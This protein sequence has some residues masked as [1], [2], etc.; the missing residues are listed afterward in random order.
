MYKLSLF[1]SWRWLSLCLALVSGTGA[2]GAPRISE[3][4]AANGSFLADEDGVFSDWIEIHNPDVSP[5]SLAGY[6]LTDNPGNLNK[7]TFPAVTLNPGAYLVVFASG[8]NRIDPAGRLHTDFQLSADGGYLAL[9]APDGVTVVSGF[10]PAYP[11]Q[12]ENESFGLGQPRRRQYQPHP[13]VES[14]GQLRERLHHG[15]AGL[16]RERQFG[17]PRSRHRRRQQP[18]LFVVRFFEPAGAAPV[19][20]VVTS[21]TLAWRGTV[22][23]TLIGAPTVNSLLGVFRCRMPG[24]ELTRWRRPS[25][26]VTWWITTRL[27][28]LRRRSTR[29]AGRCPV[30]PGIS[31]RSCRNGSIIPEWRSAVSS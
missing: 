13:G 29:C 24:M 16:E 30:S 7:W 8:K 17:Q 19:G 14:A 15:Q 1:S 3:F 4:M 10:A 5:I 25:L 28:R 2:F 26:V 18:G 20:A 27:T 11:Q 31:P 23:S 22:S 9:V 12:F 21:A 6:H